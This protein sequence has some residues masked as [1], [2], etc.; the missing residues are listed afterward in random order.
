LANRGYKEISLTAQDT[1]KYGIDIY[2]KKMLANLLESLNNLDGIKWIR[3][4][5][6]YPEDIDDELL[7]SISGLSKVIKYFD[8]PIQHINDR[9]LKL[10]NRKTTPDKI[11]SVIEKIRTQFNEA[12]IRTTVMVGFPTETDQE[13][14]ELC[15][16]I[17]WAQFDRLGAFIYSQ[18]EGT[19]AAGLSQVD[20]EK[21]LKRYERILNIQKRI[22]LERNKQ[23]IGKCYEVVIENKDRNNFYIARSQFES[24]EVDGNIIVFSK[25]KLHTGMFVNVKILDAFEYDLVG[26]VVR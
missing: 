23:R 17:K 19:F 14:D 22:S 7:Y 8:I 3:F 21:K 26:E 6:S 2:G 4:L 12:C 18:E 16:F 15:E 9:I 24:P 1:T 25:E 5:Y 13:F 10:M 11:R 20:D